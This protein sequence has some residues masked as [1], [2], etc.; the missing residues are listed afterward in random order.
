MIMIKFESL[1]SAKSLVSLLGDGE[2]DTLS[3]GKGDVRLVA[4]AD[5]EDISNPGSEDVAISVLD[6]DNVEGAGMSLTGHDGSHPTG[7][8]SSGD[9]AQVAGVELDGVLD[10][11][12]GDVHLDAVV[13]PDDG[14]GVADGS[15]VSGVEVGDGIRAGL[16]LPDLAE[17]VLGLLR[18]DPVNS[19]PSLHVVDDTEVLASLLDLDNIHE[20]SGELR[21]SAGLSVNLD[22]P[23]LEDGL[24]LLGV[25]GI[26]QT[27]PELRLIMLVI[28][29]QLILYVVSIEKY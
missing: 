19:E 16:D 12:G 27:V 25:E 29:L 10:L 1:R 13:H 9:H 6:V 23:L 14:V 17:L 7:V 3:L 24:D 21:I 15:A 18:S 26:L 4:L 5:D 2:L 22:Q 8:T 20:A 28:T 11:A